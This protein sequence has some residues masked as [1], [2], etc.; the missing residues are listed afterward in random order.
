MTLPLVRMFTRVFGA[1]Y[2]HLDLILYCDT[3]DINELD[4]HL[5]NRFFPNYES[6]RSKHVAAMR[7]T[8]HP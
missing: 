7:K 2:Q 6:K 1:L 4:T 3:I 5:N 8:K